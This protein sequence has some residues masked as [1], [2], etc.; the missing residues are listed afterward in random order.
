[1]QPLSH[2]SVSIAVSVGLVALMAGVADAKPKLAVLG[3]ESIDQGKAN[4]ELVA[5]AAMMSTLLRKEVDR[6]KSPFELATT[7]PHNL[8]DVKLMYDCADENRQCM[9]RISK[10][11]LKASRVIYG[12][13][14]EQPGKGYLFQLTLLNGSTEQPEG[15]VTEVVPYAEARRPGDASRWARSFYNLLIG[16][17]EEGRLRV[18]A[19]VDRA[20][21]YIDNDL[22]GNLSDGEATIPNVEAGQRSVRVEAE[23]SSAESSVEVRA[24]ETAELELEL[25]SLGGGG[26]P[27]PEGGSGRLGWQIGF[28]AGAVGTVAAASAWAYFGG[29]AGQ[30]PFA[31]LSEKGGE[32]IDA[33]RDA[34]FNVLPSE[35]QN[36]L[37]GSCERA[38]DADPGSLQLDGEDADNFNAYRGICVEGLDN[39]R[40]A[41]ISLVSMGVLAAVTIGL[42]YP[43]FL[44]DDGGTGRDE[45]SRRQHRKQPRV[46]IIPGGPGD[47]GAGLE[48]TF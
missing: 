46:R 16:V 6:P 41:T 22:V 42:I 4:R 43:A 3:I 37:G 17:K 40:K 19:N 44:R 30:G 9:S 23:G 27:G 31:S 33:R 28:V 38:R 14:A 15:T 7:P 8:I 12:T 5:A 2:R 20:T 21:V 10:D 39:A 34:A 26:A 36:T 35:T 25:V 24:G 45:L 13:V 32:R 47:I 18:R 1:M 48:I 11:V 29:K